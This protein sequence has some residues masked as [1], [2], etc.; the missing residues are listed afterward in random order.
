MNMEY[1]SLSRMKA[2]KN[3]ALL[4]PVGSGVNLYNEVRPY[5]SLDYLTPNEFVAKGAR[6]A[7]P[8][9]DGPGRCDIRTGEDDFSVSRGLLRILRKKARAYLEIA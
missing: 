8:S 6:P 9:G 1:A 4:S 7:S 3:F 2:I 5:A